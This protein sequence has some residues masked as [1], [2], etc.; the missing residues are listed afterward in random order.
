[1]SLRIGIRVLNGIVSAFVLA[2]L[3]AM[4]RIAFSQ[5]PANSASVSNAQASSA[6]V[7]QAS[8]RE[9]SSAATG[10]LQ[11]GRPVQDFNVQYAEASL[12][13]A[14]LTL[15]QAIQANQRFPGTYS[16]VTIRCLQSQ[17]A[18]AQSRLQLAQTGGNRGLQNILL[19]EID[20][21]LKSA[22]AK[23]QNASASGKPRTPTGAD[24]QLLQLAVEVERL[25]A[26][27]AQSPNASLAELLQWQIEELHQ[28]L[29]QQQ[30]EIDQL[31][32]LIRQ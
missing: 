2:A 20:G 25:A 10:Q 27:R 24:V 1:M 32:T 7:V 23:L 15:R 19:S 31:L 17:V 29:V 8:N 28:Q 30:L 26:Q 21:N 9:P 13:L 12:K 16:A 3:S 4:P 18:V 11:A 5:E 22:E 6:P 14:E